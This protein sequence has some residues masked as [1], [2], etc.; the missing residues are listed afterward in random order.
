MPDRH[1]I[2]LPEHGLSNSAARRNK[3]WMK[4]L[5]AV[6]LT[7]SNGFAFK[8]AFKDHGTTVELEEGAWVMSYMEDRRASGRLEWHNV[9]LYQVRGGTLTEVDDWRI[10]GDDSGWALQV[11]DDIHAY[12]TTPAEPAAPA[13]SAPAE[14]AAAAGVPAPVSPG[15][16]RIAPG[17]ESTPTVLLGDAL[18]AVTPELFNAGD[19]NRASLTIR[20]RSTA[21]GASNPATSE[22]WYDLLWTH[23]AVHAVEGP[24]GP[25]LSVEH[26]EIATAGTLP[27]PPRIPVETR[28]AAAPPVT[29]DH[30]SDDELRVWGG[31]EKLIRSWTG[32]RDAA[33][34]DDRSADAYDW[35]TYATQIAAQV[36]SLTAPRLTAG[37]RA[38]VA[39][40]RL[41][42][43]H[44]A[45]Q[46]ARAS[47][48]A[49]LGNADRAG[50]AGDAAAVRE[51]LPL[52]DRPTTVTA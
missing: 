50:D 31:A 12:M 13:I 32:H 8:G 24:H 9:T 49:L 3:I 20:P 26:V 51:L 48:H 39:A 1:V 28:I 5:T 29:V 22:V 18:R 42:E 46:G 38:Q 4:L 21:L 16:L 10:D 34:R 30:L 23:P 43:A 14:P 40:V 45:L 2:T 17:G 41:I 25:E 52:I 47:V 7:E 15:M 33:L 35:S 36:R 44:W 19:R 37:Q 11:R 27:P 6:D